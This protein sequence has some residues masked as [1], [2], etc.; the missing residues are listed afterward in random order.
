MLF[1][2]QNLLGLLIIPGLMVV[3]FYFFNKYLVRKID[4]RESG[5]KLLLY[6]VVTVLS[7]FIYVSIGIFLII[8]VALW[9]K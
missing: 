9:L 8:R 1:I 4:P 6:F 5:K 3:P 7:V 2:I